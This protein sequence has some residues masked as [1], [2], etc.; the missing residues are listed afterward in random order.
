MHHIIKDL[1]ILLAVSLPINI[2]FHKIKLPSVMGFLIAGV[3]IGPYG[4]HWVGEPESVKSLAEI[5]VI[6]L[7][8]VIGLEFSL[9]RILN[10]IIPI[11]GVGGFQ[12]ILTAIAVFIVCVNF[13]FPLNQGI[14]LGLFFAL[15]STA[16][17]IKMITDRAEIDTQHGKI[18]I[19]VL[20]IQD[21]AVVPIMLLIPLLSSGG[22][23]SIADVG[24]ALTKSLT[25]IVAMFLLARLI[26]PKTLALI[27]RLG[28]KEH[29]TLFVILLILGTCW[30]CNLLGIS[31]AM[32]AFIAGLIL[33]ESEY[34][35]Q[36]ILDILP[37]RDYFGSIFFISVGMLLQTQ[38]FFDSIF[39]FLGLTCGIIFLKA[40]LASIASLI[41]K[42]SLRV[43]FII[44]LRLAQA[45]EFS[46]LLAGIALERG[47]FDQNLYQNFLIISILSM[48]AAPIIIQASS[49]LSIKLFSK[50]PS[51]TSSHRE[52]E[53]DHNKKLEGHVIIAGYGL[54]GRNLARVL[55]EVMTPF[56]LIELKGEKIKQALTKSMNVLYGDA[57]HSETLRM[58]GVTTAR[59]IVFAL[60]DYTDAEQG[61]RIARKL[62]PNIYIIVRT[63]YMAQV[64]ELKLAGADQVIPEEFETSIEIFSRVLKE[65]NI[66]NNIIEQQVELI[67][68]E[69]Y[70]MFRGLSLNVESMAK[71][72]SFL[73]ASLTEAYQ[74]LEDSWAN[75]K[76]LKDIDLPSHTGAK[77]IAIVRN[78][79]IQTTFEE[80]YLIKSGDSL[81]LFGRHAQL[82]KSI[83]IL[84]HGHF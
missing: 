9:R 58:A 62:N 64:E 25:A 46:F 49:W 51:Q 24:I 35:H 17:I 12:I 29:L 40:L 14:A 71:F 55:K 8:F 38:I 36:I 27:A 75:N 5:G 3:L 33:S 31:L 63:R 4:L 7:L 82:D 50:L 59:M 68:M 53:A 61:V 20:L 39:L 45:G 15:S 66:S 18:C 10:N 52:Q 48:L 26:I 57:T 84:R 47:L 1:T 78:E 43:S 76:K 22:D 60:R 73:T 69:G 23:Y 42:N 79:R 77:L 56:L 19:G 65:F 72:S 67:R 81:I 16:I 41:L 11:I 44:G 70:S 83:K 80:D 54:V 30:I 28:S 2:L 32:G 37:L 21:V 34:S 74:V 13:G 6:L